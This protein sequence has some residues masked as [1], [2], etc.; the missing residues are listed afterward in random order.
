MNL[1]RLTWGVRH[2]LAGSYIIESED[3]YPIV[4]YGPMPATLVSAF[5][6]ER[7]TMVAATMDRTIKELNDGP[8]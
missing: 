3:G 8:Q 6:R 1:Y 4:T 2:D 7:Y 5:L